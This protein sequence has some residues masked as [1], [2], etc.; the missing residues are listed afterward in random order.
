MQRIEAGAARSRELEKHLEADGS[1]IQVL[2]IDGFHV[3]AEHSK[4]RGVERVVDLLRVEVEASR[5]ML[6]S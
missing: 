5:K 6:S 3:A 2:F 1:C 4:A